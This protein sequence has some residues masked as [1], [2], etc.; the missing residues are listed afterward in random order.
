M[1]SK[2]ED[3]G[4]FFMRFEDYVRAFS[5][6]DIVLTSDDGVRTRIISDFTNQCTKFF[7]FEL[8]KDIDTTKHVFALTVM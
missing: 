3:D 5:S 7:T 2:I 6:T 8:L 1:G 4:Y